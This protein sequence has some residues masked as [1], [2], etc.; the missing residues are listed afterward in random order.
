MPSGD[1]G[2]KCDV[3]RKTGK[4]K[5]CPVLSLLLLPHLFFMHRSRTSP[6]IFS[7]PIPSLSKFHLFPPSPG[8]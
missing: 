4:E 6:E 1:G 8:L 3:G 7:S 2:V 5:M